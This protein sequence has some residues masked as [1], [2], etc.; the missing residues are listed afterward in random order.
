MDTSYVRLPE[1]PQ[2]L[3]KTT[4][5]M[6]PS[7]LAAEAT[8]AERHGAAHA[9]TAATRRAEKA[10]RPGR[11]AR[12]RRTPPSGSIVASKTDSSE[13]PRRTRPHEREWAC[14]AVRH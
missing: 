12:R 6:R 2:D 14:C 3:S 9:T 13:A 11:A 10:P 1:G 5:F 8:S 7:G 4:A